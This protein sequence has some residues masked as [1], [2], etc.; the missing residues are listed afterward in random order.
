[1]AVG[2]GKFLFGIATFGYTLYHPASA[3]AIDLDEYIMSDVLVSPSRNMYVPGCPLE[4]FDVA[5][6]RRIIRT[7]MILEVIDILRICLSLELV[8]L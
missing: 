7:T 3:F 4:M 6:T 2:R 5:C 1:M 8:I